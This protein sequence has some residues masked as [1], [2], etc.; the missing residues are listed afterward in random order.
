MEGYGE[1]IAWLCDQCCGQ[2]LYLLQHTCTKYMGNVVSLRDYYNSYKLYRDAECKTNVTLWEY[3][4]F[5]M[6]ALGK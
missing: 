4:F 5:F 3:F 1:E 2:R 6:T